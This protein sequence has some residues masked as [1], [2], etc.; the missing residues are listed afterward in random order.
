M[1]S[2]WCVYIYIY[3]YIYI[4]THIHTHTYIYI[5]FPSPPSSVIP[6]GGTI[7]SHSNHEFSETNHSRLNV[8]RDE[9]N[10]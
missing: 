10:N 1:D 8:L 7:H 6:A 5:F 3:I 9:F 2:S 4:H